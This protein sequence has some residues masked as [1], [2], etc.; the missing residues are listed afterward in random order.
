MTMRRKDLTGQRFG[1][2]LARWVAEVDKWRTA[3]WECECDCGNITTVTSH[4]LLSGNTHSCGCLLVEAKRRNG[5][6]SAVHGHRYSRRM[7]RKSSITYNSWAA[8]IARCS[9]PNMEAYPN[10]GGRE[11]SVCDR[12]KSFANFLEDMGERPS[13]LTIERIDNDGNY[14]PSNCKWATRKEQVKNRRR[15]IRH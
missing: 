5:E 1:R 7:G 13:G 9:N 4:N 2:L 12:W 6:A 3:V 8:M 11:I 10:Y 14:E 15:R